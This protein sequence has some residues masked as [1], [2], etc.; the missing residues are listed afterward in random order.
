[1]RNVGEFFALQKI[2]LMA[3]L[4]QFVRS[5]VSFPISGR[6]SVM[7]DYMIALG[8]VMLLTAL[9]KML[10]PEGDI[11]KFATFAMGFMLICAVVE[12]VPNLMK[13]IKLDTESFSYDEEDINKAE[14]TFRA[15]VIKKHRENLNSLIEEK[16]VHGSKAYVETSENG[17]IISVTLWLRG[18]ESA[19][20]N[21]IA[22]ELLVPR[23]RIKLIYENN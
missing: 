2:F 22:S 3:L 5:E 9:S 6:G 16:M 4:S 20:V 18:D 12:P 21:Y 15:Q 8:T 23:E 17:E 19:A 10:L 13:E 7:R 11:K 1:M 14:A